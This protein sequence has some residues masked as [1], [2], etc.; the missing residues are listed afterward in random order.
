MSESRS[1]F[2]GEGSVDR[3]DG[4]NLLTTRGWLTTTPIEFQNALL[5]GCLWHQVEPGT[6]IQTGFEENGEFIGLADGIVQ[7][8]TTVS[9]PEAPVIHFVRP[10]FWFGYFPILFRERRGMTATAKTAAWLARVP[11]AKV[12]SLLGEHPNWILNFLPLAHSYGDIAIVIAADL[13][14]RSSERRCAAV[15]LRLAGC[16]FADPEQPGPAEVPVTQDELA[17]A[18]NLS[19][20]TAGVILRKLEAAGMVQRGFRGVSIL[21]PSA[22]RRYVEV[23]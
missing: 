1:R 2:F 13:L 12:R 22:L 20:N 10:V 14:I 16:R 18:A 4:L 17:D 15:L 9:I 5:S 6:L 21:S 7:M 8:T 3:D 11:H 23:G 19:R